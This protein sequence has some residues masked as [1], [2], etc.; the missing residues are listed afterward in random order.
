MNKQPWT[1]LLVDDED[2]VIEVSKLVLEDLTFD[3]LPLRILSARCAQDARDIFE[4]ENDI[5][6]ALIDVVME[7]EHAGL[8]LVRYVREKQGNQLTRLILRTGNP[9][10]APQR[11]IVRHLEIDDYKEKTDLTADRLETTVLTSLRSYRN[12]KARLRMER[13]LEQMLDASASLHSN[14]STIEFLRIALQK[15]FT[16]VQVEFDSE[17]DHGALVL[18]RNDEDFQVLAGIHG[19][20]SARQEDERYKLPSSILEELRSVEH[21]EGISQI[22]SG[23]VFTVSARAGQTYHFWIGTP[24]QLPSDSIRL[25]QFFLGKLSVSLSNSILRR[26]VLDAQSDVLNRLCEAIESRSKETGSH[27]RRIALYSRKL[28]MLA[29]LNDDEVELITAA[30]PMHDIGKVAI[31][32]SIL[33]KPGKLDAQQWEVMK[34]HAH[35]GFRLLAHPSFSVMQAGAEIANTHHERWD[36]TGYPLGLIGQQ[37][38]MMGRIVALVDVFDALLS[39]RP[40]K[41]PWPLEKVID[42]IRSLRGKQFDPALTDIFLDHIDSFHEIFTQFPD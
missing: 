28:A 38:P 14:V 18:Q 13:G 15:I 31:P 5:A 41:D 1:I 22:K 39:R 3:D 27:I 16:I 11:E 34:T 24:Y 33:N 6:L 9:G 37:I 30:S 36:G 42:E 40:Y 17:L 29:G 8:D 10:A 21:T 7:T 20:E 2:D 4:S 26:E 25:L 23:V 35:E 32:D 12:I 19:V